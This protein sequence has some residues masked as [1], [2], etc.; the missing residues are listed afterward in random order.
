MTVSLPRQ[1][2]ADKV[3]QYLKAQLA[4]RKHKVGDRLNARRIADELDVSRTTIN[5]AIERLIKEG[6]VKVNQSRHG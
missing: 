6:L 4:N 2:L 5:K 3:C 1:S